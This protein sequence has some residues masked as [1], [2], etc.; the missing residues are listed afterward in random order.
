MYVGPVSSHCFTNRLT[1]TPTVQSSSFKFLHGT[2]CVFDCF[3]RMDVRVEISASGAMHSYVHACLYLKRRSTSC[4]VPDMQSTSTGHI[5]P[6]PM[7]HGDSVRCVRYSFPLSSANDSHFLHQLL[8]QVSS[9]L[10]AL[11]VIHDIDP[12]MGSDG[13]ALTCPPPIIHNPFHTCAA[14]TA[15]LAKNSDVCSVIRIQ[16]FC[17]VEYCN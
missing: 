12:A 1:L 7:T 16:A 4:I 14:Q 9:I 11:N 3:S 10:R 2:Y 15:F 8:H 17:I 5:S 13:H 6:S